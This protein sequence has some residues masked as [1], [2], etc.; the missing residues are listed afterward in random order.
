MAISAAELLTAARPDLA[1]SEKKSPSK[2][3]KLRS[4]SWLQAM[5]RECWR[6]GLPRSERR[7]WDRPRGEKC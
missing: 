2:I 5:A 4:D 7:Y 3:A 6:T 1:V